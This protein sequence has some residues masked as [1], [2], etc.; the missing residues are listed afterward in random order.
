MWLKGLVY[1]PFFTLLIWDFFEQRPVP[2]G[3]SFKPVQTISVVIPALNESETIAV[4]IESVRKERGLLET[5]VVD[6]GSSD[7]TSAISENLGA[8]VME[9]EQGRGHSNQDRRRHVPWGR[10]SDTS[11]RLLDQYLEHLNGYY[12]NS[13]NA[14][15][16]L[17]VPWACA[18]QSSLLKSN[19][20]P[21]SIICAPAW[22][23]ISFGDQGQFLR[24]QAMDAIG[25]VPEQMLMED[26]ELS[27]RLKENGLVCHIHRGIIASH[28]RWDDAGFFRNS[29]KVVMLCL[30]YLIKR[31][32]GV[33]EDI[34]GNAY[35]SRYYSVDSL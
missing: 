6:G 21:Y 20:S 16:V 25:G 35:Y 17:A 8:M 23:G 22:A 32:L 34:Q 10:D 4:A 12:K 13:I 18:I 28:R 24:A 7:N 33:E 29:G 31:R 5:I 26:V 15:S 11:C 30:E 27:L 1:L 3:E 19:A 9:S 2:S 14:L